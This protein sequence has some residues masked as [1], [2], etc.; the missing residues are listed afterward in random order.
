MLGW[1]EFIHHKHLQRLYYYNTLYNFTEKTFRPHHVK[2]VCLFAATQYTVNLTLEREIT[3]DQGAS[4]YTDLEKME[5]ASFSLIQ[6][7]SS[8]HVTFTAFTLDE[9]T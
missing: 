9:W 5:A 8:F 4:F 1:K 7:V 2:H 3:D 6:E